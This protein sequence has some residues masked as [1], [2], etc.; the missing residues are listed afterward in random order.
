M[1]D[2]VLLITDIRHPALHFSP[3]LYDYVTKKLKK[4][5]ILVLNKIDLAP[6]AMVVA[7]RHY[8]QQKFP[9]LQIVCFTSFPKNLEEL[10]QSDP[11][12]GQF[13]V[14][15]LGSFFNISFLF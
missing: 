10:Q 13:E 8:F 7:W 9:D 11:G 3:A 6:P 14:F 4:H 15:N 2:V 1:S 5:L 12:K